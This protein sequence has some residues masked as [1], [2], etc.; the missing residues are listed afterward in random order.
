MDSRWR[1]LREKYRVQIPK[2]FETRKDRCPVKI[3]RTYLAKLP[4]DLRTSGLFYLAA[5]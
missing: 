2:M 4:A 5:I 3:F 1:G